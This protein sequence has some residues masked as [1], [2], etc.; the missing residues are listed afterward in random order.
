M[1]TQPIKYNDQVTANNS[2]HNNV[3]TTKKNSNLDKSKSKSMGGE[4][5]REQ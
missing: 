5:Y 3:S 2:I 4:D 1:Q